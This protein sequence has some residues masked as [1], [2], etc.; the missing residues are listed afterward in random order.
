MIYQYQIL[1]GFFKQS[2]L[3]PGTWLLGSAGEH[4]GAVDSSP[5]RWIN[6]VSRLEE[7]NKSCTPNETVKLLWL[8]RH[9]QGYHNAAQ[10]KYQL[11]WEGGYALKYGDSEYTWGPDPFL[12]PL[13][14]QQ[15]RDDH[16]A[17]VA[18]CKDGLSLPDSWYCSPMRRAASTL[19]LTFGSLRSM[20][21][22][23]IFVEE[24]R[25]HLGVNTCDKRSS[26]S[27]LASEYPS[28]DFHEPFDEE[29]ELWVP[30]YREREP[31][32][33][34]RLQAAL[35][36]ILDRE[37]DSSKHISITAHSGA[38][39]ALCT[40]LGHP[41]VALPTGGIIPVVVKITRAMDN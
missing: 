25:E 34:I 26:K 35:N 31:E 38:I 5:K 22:R 27:I 11:E 32:M 36:K 14:E 16:E 3:I 33:I 29:D 15:A 24:L 18:E 7:L 13:G 21:K 23:P 9:G 10:T 41:T 28:F 6:L 2:E 12:T 1:H 17:W 19:M 40:A 8:A 30:D 20:V 37:W 39:R 4:F